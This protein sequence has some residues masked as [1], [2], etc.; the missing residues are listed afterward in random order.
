MINKKISILFLFSLLSGVLF[1][2]NQVLSLQDCRDKA[3]AY[4]KSLRIASEE[5]RVAYYEKKEAYLMFFPKF[6]LNVAYSHFSNDLHL[7]SS[8]LLSGIPTS[9]TVPDLTQYGLPQLIPAGTEIP[10]SA[11]ESIKDELSSASTIDLSN[12]WVGGVS[13][14]QPLFAGGKI[15]AN[16]Q[17]RTYAL[18]L[19]KSKADTKLADVIVEV[20]QA[21][22]QVVSLSSKKT[23]A[24]SYVALLSKIDSDLELMVKGGVATKAD[25]LSVDVKL[26]EAEMA[27]TKVDNGLSL[28]KMLLCELCGIEISDQ[29]TVA[30]ENVKNVAADE[31][32]H[33]LVN[34][35]EAL[36]HRPEIRSL[37]LAE[38]IYK[39]KEK[40]AFAE[41]LP[42]VG[43][44]AG[45]T[46][47]N[48]SCFDGL[49]YKLKGMWNVGVMAT[50]PLNYLT[51]SAKYNAAKSETVIKQLELD[52]AKEKIRL[53]I[54]Q[55]TYKLIEAKKKLESAEKNIESADE[56]LR[57]ANAGFEEG[58]IS[59]S[60]VLAA[61]TAWIQA[62]SDLLD[63]QI[64]LKMCRVYLDRAVGN[65]LVNANI[66]PKF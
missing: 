13:L 2:Q 59:A 3:V 39:K 50:I 20:D 17:I 30:D 23:L 38:Q 45:Y 8:S 4:N 35:D 12:I 43:L 24:E 33:D 29:V 62:H 63:A 32:Q 34:I 52:D 55:S 48:P 60:D 6:S 21:Y 16:N 26:N 10:F 7:L 40:V 51:S 25:K 54:N 37:T 11:G 15:L 66:H 1:S 46:W 58:V 53:Q 47:T 28:S 57:Y 61:H 41:F 27:L 49:E 56:N 9:I 19:A 64:E 42:T 65:Q 31:N 18:E 5:E 14:V 22:W 36:E 44:T